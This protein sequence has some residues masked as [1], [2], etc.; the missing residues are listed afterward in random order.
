MPQTISINI[1]SEIA[2]NTHG[3]MLSLT[4]E[5]RSFC[6]MVDPFLLCSVV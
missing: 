4:F 6:R 5:G 2:T 3:N 1:N